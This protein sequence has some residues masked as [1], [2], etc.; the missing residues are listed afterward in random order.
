MVGAESW[1]ATKLLNKVNDYLLPLTKNPTLQPSSAPFDG[2][3]VH[4]FGR[5]LRMFS[6]SHPGGPRAR[7]NPRTA[8]RSLRRLYRSKRVVASFASR[9]QHWS[10]RSPHNQGGDEHARHRQASHPCANSAETFECR[11]RGILG[12]VVNTLADVARDSWSPPHHFSPGDFTRMGLVLYWYGNDIS[13]NNL[14][15]ENPCH[16]TCCST[17]VGLTSIQKGGNQCKG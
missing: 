8:N 5:C 7:K 15:G 16:A 13:S 9:S 10:G 4:S 17:M 6:S 1:H 12:S 3:T 14:T 11:S 2:M